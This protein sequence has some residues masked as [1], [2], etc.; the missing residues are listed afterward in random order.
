MAAKIS[1]RP[2]ARLIIQ[3]YIELLKKEKIPVEQVIVFG[4]QTN[5][6]ASEKSDIYLCVVS[7]A[8]GKNYHEEMV[9]L[10]VLASSL[11]EPMDV[12]PFTPKDLAD[13]YDSLAAEIRRYGVP[14]VISH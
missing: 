10:M 14:L 1:L 5:G 8:F 2:V 11:H 13:K 12:V 7:S 4:S 6:T 9:R 3:K